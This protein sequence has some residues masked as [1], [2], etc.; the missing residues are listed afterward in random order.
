MYERNDEDK[1]K[2]KVK[3]QHQRDQL[4]HLLASQDV[5]ITSIIEARDGYA[6]TSMKQ[7]EQDTIFS[8]ECQTALA[9]KDFCIVTPPDLKPKK[10]ILMFNCPNEVTRNSYKDI[11]NGIFRVN[12]FTTNNVE[13]IY[14]L[15]DKPILK[16]M[17]K[18]ASIAQKAQETGMRL[19]NMPIPPPTKLK[20][21]MSLSPPACVAMP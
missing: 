4:L 8:P 12:L 14:K 15:P 9:I 10:T 21:N 11:K 7:E 1:N 18:Q 5:Y 19:Y 2:T 20:K 13:E 6:I 3:N 16:V 17:F